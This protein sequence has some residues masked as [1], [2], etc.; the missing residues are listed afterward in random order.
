MNCGAS[1][2]LRQAENIRKQSSRKHASKAQLCKESQCKES[3]QVRVRYEQST[4]MPTPCQLNFQTPEWTD[5]RDAIA[6][7]VTNPTLLSTP[8][9]YSVP[10]AVAIRCLLR[11]QEAG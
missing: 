11:G 9:W 8:L 4:I 7:P 6:P 3:Q 1:I 5:E 10:T 2:L